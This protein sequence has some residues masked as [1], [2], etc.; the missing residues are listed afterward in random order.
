MKKLKGLLSKGQKL[1]KQVTELATDASKTAKD[2]W[3]ENKDELQAQGKKALETGQKYASSTYESASEAAFS[4]YRDIKYSD[5]D[6]SKLQKNIVNQGG[7]Y[8]ELNRRSTSVDTLILGGETLTTLIASGMISDEI[9]DAYKAAY[10]N[11][12]DTISFEDKVRELDDEALIG[13]I[14]GV[15]GKLFEQKYVEY[16]N[17]GNLP[18]GYTAVLAESLTQPGWDIA[19]KGENGELA[20]VLQAK[21]TDSISYVQNA[22]EKYPS[23]DVVTT[24]EVYSHLVMSGISENITNGSISN[25]ELIEELDG[26]LYASELA[27]DY[28]PPIFALAFIAFTSYKDE[29]LTLYEK[30]RSAG[31]RSGKTYLSYIVG[32]GVAAITNTWWLGVLGSVGSRILT[33]SGDRKYEMYNKLKEI[34]KNNQLII[35]NMKSV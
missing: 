31:N 19:I 30:A 9:I 32:G 24:D 23:I 12:S 11:L 15:K 4:I 3:V 10:P 8:R 7:Y 26:A 29:S 27:M 13:F 25:A 28:S 5:G 14:S 33:D 17:N 2:Y 16:L 1:A 6:L 21:A 22:L 20:S 34:E 18:D 35:E